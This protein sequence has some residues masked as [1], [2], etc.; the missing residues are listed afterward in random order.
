[1]LICGCSAMVAG[2]CN[3]KTLNYYADGNGR[4]RK[5]L[6]VAICLPPSL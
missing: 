4:W 6:N 1:M 2:E 3:R 5:Q